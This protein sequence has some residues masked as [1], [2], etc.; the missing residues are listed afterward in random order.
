MILADFGFA[1]YQNIGKLESYRGS[2]TYIAP[3]IH[4]GKIYDGRQVDVFSAGVILFVIVIGVF[5]FIEAKSDE[6]DY[7]L[8]YKGQTKRYW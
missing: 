1:T 2:K 7:S 6:K 3:E 4:E 8:L 5:P